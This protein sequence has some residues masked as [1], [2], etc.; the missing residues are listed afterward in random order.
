MKTT[1]IFT[2][3]LTQIVLK[4]ESEQ[5]RNILSLFDKGEYNITVHRSRFSE[6]CAGYIREY[7]Q[8]QDAILCIRP[9]E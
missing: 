1:A 6:C 7:K 2:E 5:E 9:K 8:D 3:G 4:P